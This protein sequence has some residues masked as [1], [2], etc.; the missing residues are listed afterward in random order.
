[1]SKKKL[2]IF[3]VIL[4]I[5]VWVVLL[6]KI[7]FTKTAPAAFS[8]S[9]KY[10]NKIEYSQFSKDTFELDLSLIKRDPFLNNRF[11]EKQVSIK[12]HYKAKRKTSAKVSWPQIQYVGFV[13]S[14][15]NKS[16]LVLLR[17]GKRLVRLRMGKGVDNFL[18][19]KIYKDSVQIKYKGE[20]RSFNKNK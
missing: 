9:N 5:A 15:A 17:I 12:K 19:K 1:M 16:P 4:L 6:K 14:E 10:T 20:V 11:R 18:V 2:N 8:I 3:L 7:F 13:K